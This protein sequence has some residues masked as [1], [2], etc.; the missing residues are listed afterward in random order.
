[1]ATYSA[2]D[3]PPMIPKT[4]SPI[5]H[6]AAPG[7]FA[8]TSPANSIPGMSAGLP[9]GAG[10]R[11]IRWSKSA[12]LSAVARTRTRISR[13]PGSGRGLFASSRTSGPPN[14]LMTTARIGEVSSITSCV[15]MPKRAA[16]P[17]GD[18]G[19]APPHRSN[20]A[21][22]Q[23]HRAGPDDRERPPDLQRLSGVRA[24]GGDLLLLSVRGPANPSHFQVRRLVG[25]RT[26]LAFRRDVGARGE[27]VGVSRLH[28]SARRVARSRASSRRYSRHR[29]DDQ[30]LPGYQEGPSPAGQA[31]RPS[32]HG[33][34]LDADRR[35][36][37]RAHGNRDLEAGATGAPDDALRGLL[38]GAI[39]ALRVDAGDRRAHGRAH[40]HG[41]HRRSLLDSIDVHRQ[42]SRRSLARGA[43]RTAA[44]PSVPGGREAGG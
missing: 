7:P 17:H 18:D 44:V 19:P 29:R 8:S 11:P 1:M 24:E 25:R 38:L 12:R 13:A 23:R 21:L 31:Q 26:Q 20:H 9:L 4:R 33:L 15:G 41:V 32:A 5:F 27:W 39:L 35:R 30:I 40:L 36:H 16:F 3:P 28:L 43:Q 37:H 22:D 14:R 10:Y 42:V 2:C 6:R 34:L